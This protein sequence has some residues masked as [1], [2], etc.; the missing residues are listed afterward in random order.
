[1]K[2]P[3]NATREWPPL[4]ASRESLH[5]VT[6]TQRSQKN[7]QTNK[8]NPQNLGGQWDLTFFPWLE[9]SPASLAESH[10]DWYIFKLQNYCHSKFSQY[11][12]PCILIVTIF[13]SHDDTFK[14][15][16]LQFNSVQSLSLVQLFATPMDYIQQARLPCPSPTPGAYSDSCPLSWWCHQPSHYCLSNFQIY[17]TVLF[18]KS[19][20]CTLHLQD[21]L[22]T[23]NLY[24]LTIFTHFPQLS[25][26]A[27]GNHKSVLCTDELK[28]ILHLSEIIWYLFFLCLTYFT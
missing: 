14:I 2:S 21:L 3:C 18:T 28:K 23:G 12:S 16:C 17:S 22:I 24:L 5:A 11:S 9:I 27:S 1:M 25:T 4:S 20:C 7:K 13:F 6:K 26:S 15:C 8:K 19:T 10:N